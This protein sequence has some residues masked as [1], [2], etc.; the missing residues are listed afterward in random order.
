ML[1][2]IC[3][4]LCRLGWNGLRNY[5]DFLDPG[6]G[7][8]NLGRVA[9]YEPERFTSLWMINIPMIGLSILFPVSL[10]EIKASRF[11]SMDICLGTIYRGEIKNEIGTTQ[12]FG[13]EL[14]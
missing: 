4:Y 10:P 1:L 8:I 14:R 5:R 6:P 9:I 7:N 3:R 2:R 12:I 13:S 11:A